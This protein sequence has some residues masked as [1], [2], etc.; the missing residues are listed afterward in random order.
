VTWPGGA[1]NA[2]VR[3]DVG[4]ARGPDGSLASATYGT[5][6]A[7]VPTLHLQNETPASVDGRACLRENSCDAAMSGGLAARDA[8]CF[9]PHPPCLQLYRPFFS[10][11]FLLLS[12]SFLLPVL[13][14]PERR[15]LR[16]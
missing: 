6:A 10:S 3:A 16:F 1:E 5:L 7:D 14:A 8:Q 12:F 13:E 2:H 11:F 15:L 9:C 4:R